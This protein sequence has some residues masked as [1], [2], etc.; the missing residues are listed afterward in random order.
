MRTA[1]SSP[2][3]SRC[4]HASV[5]R[6]LDGYRAVDPGSTNGTSVNKVRGVAH[7][8]KDG[9]YFQVGKCIYRFLAGGNVEV[10]YHEEIYRLAIIDALTGL[11][12]KR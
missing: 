11:H 1:T 12:N 4:R 3:T 5:E 9:D 2:T 7:D 6:A 8:L 10:E